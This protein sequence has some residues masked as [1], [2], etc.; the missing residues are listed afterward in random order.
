MKARILGLALAA[1]TAM[2]AAQAGIVSFDFTVTGAGGTIPSFVETRSTNFVENA[3]RM[4]AVAGSYDEVTFF[5]NSKLVSHY[6]TSTYDVSGFYRDIYDF[7]G[8]VSGPDGS[9][10]Y[11]YLSGVVTFDPS[12][13]HNMGEVSP[14]MDASMLFSGTYVQ[15]FNPEFPSIP[16]LPT[17]PQMAVG[18]GTTKADLTPLPAS[19][20]FNNG[21]FSQVNF[22]DGIPLVAGQNALQFLLYA[23]ADLDPSMTL[24][25]VAGPAYDF[26]TYQRTERAFLGYEILPVPEPS[27]WAMLLAGVG[28]LGIAR[29]RKNAA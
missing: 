22:I 19:T 4:N 28:I 20:S 10:K 23:G 14:A 13:A 18:Y 21:M 1:L 12:A 8:D 3:P 7:N 15:A 2:P 17:A 24:A 25:R 16:M 5:G 29:R 11:A 6:A 26:G 27:T 9:A